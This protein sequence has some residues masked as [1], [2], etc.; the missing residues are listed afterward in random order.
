MPGL[1]N[2]PQLWEQHSSRLDSELLKLLKQN[3]SM[4]G[5]VGTW[6]LGSPRLE[7]YTRCMPR[8]PGSLCPH[9]GTVYKGRCP[10]C[11][12][13]WANGRRGKAWAPGRG[14]DPQ[15]DRVRRDQLDAHPVCQ[16]P[17]GCPELATQ[18]DHVDGTDYETERYDRTKLRSLCTDHHRLRTTMQGNAAQ[19]RGVGA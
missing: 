16:W 1:L 15:W 7:E 13:G 17:S 14:G 3:I 19:G 12:S 10:K 18:V 8:S 6:D 9:C 4:E 5:N 2:T 11:S